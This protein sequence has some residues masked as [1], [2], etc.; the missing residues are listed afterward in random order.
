M[1]AGTRVPV[2]AEQLQG[3]VA[4]RTA[5]EAAAA[6]ERAR[7]PRVEAG[8][9]AAMRPQLE[10]ERAL[11]AARGELQAAQAYIGACHCN[12]FAVVQ[13]CMVRRALPSWPCL[14]KLY[15]AADTAAADD[16]NGD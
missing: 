2:Q 16:G 15:A 7:I 9:D 4:A 11:H 14:D 12:D 13:R 6:A 10:G 3:E 8:A 5:A 1:K